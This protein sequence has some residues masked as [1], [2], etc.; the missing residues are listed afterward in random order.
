MMFSD[1]RR[2]ALLATSALLATTTVGLLLASLL[3][4]IVGL[5]T[6]AAGSARSIERD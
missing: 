2:R 6:M 5:I 3:C 1:S 4:A